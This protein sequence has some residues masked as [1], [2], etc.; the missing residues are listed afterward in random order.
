MC[1]RFL[2]IEFILEEF[3]VEGNVGRV[4]MMLKGDWFLKGDGLSGWIL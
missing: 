2:V 3:T 1:L 4:V